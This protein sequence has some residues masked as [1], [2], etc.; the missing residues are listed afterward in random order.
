M[1]RWFWSKACVTEADRTNEIEAMFAASGVVT[2]KLLP[3]AIVEGAA[4]IVGRVPLKRYG[5][6]DTRRSAG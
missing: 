6:E 3:K 2:E 1:K 5:G 4:L